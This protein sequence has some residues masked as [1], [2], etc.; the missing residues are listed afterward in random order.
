MSFC[1]VKDLKH[2]ETVCKITNNSNEIQCTVKKINKALIGTPDPDE[3]AELHAALTHLCY[4]GENLKHQADVSLLVAY[5]Y[6]RSGICV[7]F[8]D[9]PSIFIYI[10]MHVNSGT[11]PS[12]NGLLQ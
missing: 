3:I 4:M 10:H 12:H 7:Q 11:G 9:A 6:N 8:T 1:S 2:L 5:Y